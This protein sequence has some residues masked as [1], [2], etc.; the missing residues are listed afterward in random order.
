MA[1]K[2]TQAEAK[3]MVINQ[4]V[5]RPNNRSVSDIESWRN[6]LKTADKGKRAKLY[7]LYEDLLLDNVL[8]SAIEKRIMAITNADLAFSRNDTNEPEIDTLMDTPEFEEILTE[9]MNAKFWGKTILELDFTDGLRAFNIPR[10]HIRADLGLI[11]KNESD[12]S[13]IPYRGDD[14]FLEVGNDKD[15]G[16]ILRAAPF[17]IYKRGGFGDWA[18]FVELFGMPDRIGKYDM[19]DDETRKILTDLFTNAG[20]A[21]WAVVPKSADIESKDDSSYSANSL[22]KDFK[23]A[24]NEEILIGIL[25][26]T[27]TTQ[28]GSSKSQSETHK[29][30][31]EGV[32]KADRRFVQRVLNKVLLPRLEKRGFPVSGGFFYFPEAGENLT[33]TERLEI[34]V[35]L[36]NEVGIDIDDD[37]FYET[38]GVPKPKGNV[39]RKQEKQEKPATE[40]KQFHPTEEQLSFWERVLSFFVSAPKEG[41]NLNH[42]CPICGGIHQYRLAESAEEF[43]TESLL[44]RVVSGEASYF[45]AEL[46]TFTSNTIKDAL[47]KGFAAK[48]FVDFEYGFEPDA[49]KTAMEMNIFHFSAAKTLTEVQQLNELWRSSTS[50]DDFRKK[51]ENI[52][53]VF[54][55][56]WLRTEY[57]TAYLT[58]ESSA[59]YYRLVEQT[60]IFKTW[61]YV[62]VGD[63]KVRDAHRSL[64]GLKLPANDPLW[65][66]IYPPNG[67][68]CRCH[69]KPVIEPMGTGEKKANKNAVR[70]YFKSKEWKIN[71]AQ[72]FGINRAKQGLV[73]ASNQMYI[74]KFPNMAGKFLDKLT[75]DK[76]GLNTVINSK[77]LSKESLPITSDTE[78]QIWDRLNKGGKITLKD[79]FGRNVSISEQTFFN[80]TSAKGRDNRIPFWDAMNNAIKSPDEIWLNNLHGIDESVFK[81]WVRDNRQS[82][83]KKMTY[84]NYNVI[85]YYNDEVLV[86]NYFINEKL[87]LELKTW[88]IMPTKPQKNRNV[89]LK[90]IWDKRRHG[91][92]IQ[93]PG[94]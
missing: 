5:I 94:I 64:N 38:Y 55:K 47:T 7:D 80:H 85:K 53:N 30:V 92:L 18:Q 28:N 91:L 60:D 70:E 15:L 21:R 9:I 57:E 74:Q 25:G 34:D 69:V 31:E 77:K 58:A 29:E 3:G 45:D 20:S 48:K 68:K 42:N 37:Y 56:N 89:D 44:K 2:T 62:T 27:M 90:K 51:S 49:L 84:D 8:A 1:K 63:D 46:Y 10:K 71:Q 87:E 59:E 33:T 13:G 72:G 65:D 39:S 75:A 86:V 83:I 88:Y 4:L 17:A 23:N 32:N 61:Q 22:Y 73:F 14:F 93:K 82:L 16:L 50:F 36:K 26:Q 24:C 41:A 11:V 19:G 12:E 43:D 52:T 54:N 66:K 40:V 79:H 78:K 6:A 35:R 76:W 67:W 81:D